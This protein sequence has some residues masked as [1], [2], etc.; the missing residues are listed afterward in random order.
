MRCFDPILMGVYVCEMI[1]RSGLPFDSCIFKFCLLAC[2]FC[3][4]FC[5]SFFLFKFYCF[6][7]IRVVLRA[8]KLGFYFFP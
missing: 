4:G 8:S 6:A 5:F 1:R 7:G 2:V 3:F